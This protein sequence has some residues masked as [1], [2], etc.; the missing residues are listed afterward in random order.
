[1]K[2]IEVNIS[3]KS[4]A[5]LALGYCV[6]KTVDRSL[7]T[8]TTRMNDGPVSRVANKVGCLIL[9]GYITSKVNT[10]ID[11]KLDAV[12]DAVVSFKE[13]ANKKEEN[14]VDPNKDT[15]DHLK[16]TVKGIMDEVNHDIEKKVREKINTTK[17]E[18]E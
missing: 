9:S 8:L 1:M 5:A 16:D 13:R 18:V 17:S 10:Y 6:N 7:E 15:M 14:P 4:I 3:G 2:N 11:E 12:A